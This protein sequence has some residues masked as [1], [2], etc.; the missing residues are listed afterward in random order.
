MTNVLQR[1]TNTIAQAIKATPAQ[2]QAAVGLLD[3]GSTVPFIAR[4]RK[5]VTG[6]LDDAQLR[7]LATLL[8]SL[9]AL[10]ERRKAILKTLT[11]QG[12]LT[13]TL[14][15]SI[16]AAPS[17]TLLEDIYAPYKTK[18]TTKASV[19]RE[20]G[21]QPL[22]D[23]LREGRTDPQAQAAAYATKTKLDTDT[24]LA[25]ARDIVIDEVSQDAKLLDTLRQDTARSG[26]LMVR[27]PKGTDPQAVETFADVLARPSKMAS[28]PTHRLLA[29]LR[30][31]KAG[32]LA[33]EAVGADP[34]AQRAKVGQA[35]GVPSKPRTTGHAWLEDAAATAWTSRIKGSVSNA[36][37][38]QAR[39]QAETAAVE[40]FAKNLKALL[41][42]PPAGP[43]VTMGIDPGVRTGIKIA[44]V[45]GTGK[46]LA[47]QTLYPFAPKRDLTG[48]KAGLAMLVRRHHVDLIAVGNGTGGRE[49]QEVVRDTLKALA[50]GPGQHTP[51]AFLI[52]EAGAS[53]YS[54]SQQASD[55]LPHL[56]VSLR[57]AVSIARRAQDPLAELIKIDP[58]ALGI[59]QYQHD[60]PPAM[61][62]KALANVVEDAVAAVGV[63]LNTASAALLGHVPGV[64]PTLGAAIVAHREANGPFANRKALRKVHRMGPKAFEQCAGFLRI[65]GGTER[66]DDTGI[67]PESYPLAKAILKTIKGKPETLIG[68]PEA[69][70]GVRAE[71]FVTKGVGLPTI[72]GIL[73]ELTRPGRDP[74]GTFTVAQLDDSIQTIDDLQTGMVLEGTVTNV[75]TFGAFV[76]LGVHQDGLIHVSQMAEHRVSDPHSVVTLGQT[77]RVK[78]LDVDTARKRIGLSLRGL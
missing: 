19:A 7:T 67:H 50:P 76:D 32:L 69:F 48:T 46:I 10:E 42:A 62:D 68:K 12:V 16:E 74:R 37:L 13:P 39:E 9:R 24:V 57:G 40:V 11:T 1:T 35:M 17:K 2:V 8:E 63:D 70:Q 60:L 77:V 38:A 61:L 5:E 22:A 51:Q 52:S 58:K 55:E 54:A 31:T 64:G 3:E 65:R 28:L 72:R 6:G 26:H 53:V 36:V 49:T 71:D 4:Y 43:Q 27:V 41:L 23:A 47:T 18:R 66:L 29:V 34:D 73:E 56:D 33:V 15:A 25:G 30:A 14:K 44:V 59:G 20:K 21:L 45:D 78:V 75:T